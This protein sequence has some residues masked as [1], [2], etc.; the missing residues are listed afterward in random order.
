MYHV[1]FLQP[2]DRFLISRSEMNALTPSLKLRHPMPK[3]IE[4][5]GS[6][7]RSGTD[8][9]KTHGADIRGFEV[10]RSGILVMPATSGKP[11]T[12][13]QEEDICLDIT[14][15]CLDIE[16]IWLD[17]EWILFGRFRIQFGH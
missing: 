10:S 1:I 13:L 12:P 15:Y 5:N 4:Y 7:V 3:S 11:A 17:I 6:S 8:A 9:K 2:L 14:D 16:W